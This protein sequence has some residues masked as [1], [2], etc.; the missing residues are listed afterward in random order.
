[1]SNS[2]KKIICELE[3]QLSAGTYYKRDFVLVRGQGAYLWDDSGRKFI[4][5]V[6]GQGSANLGHRNPYVNQAIRDQVDKLIVC[7]ELFYHEERARLLEKLS[8]LTPIS[9]KR[10]F[11]CNSGSEAIEGAIKFARLAT[12]RQKIVATMRGFHG[13]SLGALSATWNKAFRQP[14]EPLVPGFTHVP[15]NNSSKV[16]DIITDQTAAFLVEVVQG[17]GGIRLASSEFLQVVQKRCQ[18]T[19][20]LFIVDEVQTGFGRTGKMFALEHFDLCPDILCLAKSMG[21]GLPIGAIGIN[22]AIASRIFKLAHTSTF[23]GNPLACAAANAA[24]RYLE[25]FRLCER[26]QELGSHF[27]S[28]LRSF[29]LPRIREVRG[30]GLMVGVEL[31]EKSGPYIQKLSKKGVLAL[32]AG[33]TLIRYLPPLVIEKDD[34]DKVADITA[35]VL[36]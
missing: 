6:G 3:D 10:F 20:T 5:C 1:M 16:I 32:A 2:P 13:K 4:D 8:R 21:G 25:E 33:P 34:L 26:A 17:E 23:G 18:E 22:Q 35:E 28:S 7:N 27:M 24:I 29:Q 11:L 15:F 12:G 14:F 30:L 19:G 31:K 36:R 9:I